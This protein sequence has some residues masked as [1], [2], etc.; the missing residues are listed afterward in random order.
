MKCPPKGRPRL[1]QCQQRWDPRCA[2]A[3]DEDNVDNGADTKSKIRPF[4][5]GTAGV[6]QVARYVCSRHDACHGWEKHCKGNGKV[7]T[8]CQ[9]FEHSA[10]VIWAVG[11]GPFG[12]ETSHRS[13]VPFKVV[14]TCL[15]FQSG[16]KFWP[17]MSVERP[18]L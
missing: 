2:D 18:S 7:D 5:N 10:A 11:V 15:R 13:V 12:V 16:M 1:G 6:L 4:R 8:P 17:M 3:E 14:T 9:C